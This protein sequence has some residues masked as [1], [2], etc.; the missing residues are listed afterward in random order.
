[1]NREIRVRVWDKESETWSGDETVD[2]LRNMPNYW[3][4][5]L[6]TDGNIEVYIGNHTKFK[7]KKENL[8]V[9]QSTGRKDKKNVELFHGDIVRTSGSHKTGEGDF[10]CEVVWWNNGWSLSGNGRYNIDKPCE[11]V[12][13]IFEDGELLE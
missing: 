1:M 2:S 3:D 7:P 11:I 10:Y 4:I 12:G 6:D 8:V 9:M 13:N 5:N